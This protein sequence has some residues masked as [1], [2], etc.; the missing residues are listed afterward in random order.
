MQTNNI[1]NWP[2]DAKF[3]TTRADLSTLQTE[4][5]SRAKKNKH[6]AYQHYKNKK[7]K[8]ARAD[9]NQSRQYRSTPPK[10]TSKKERKKEMT[11]GKQYCAAYSRNTKTKH[12]A[13]SAALQNYTHSRTWQPAL[14][15]IYIYIL[16]AAQ[17]KIPNNARRPQHIINR[18]RKPIQKKQTSCLPT[19][20]KKNEHGPISTNPGNKEARH[21][22]ARQ[23]KKEKKRWHAEI[24]T[25]Q[26]A[27]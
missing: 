15:K 20:Q 3:Q 22:K 14:P 19:L 6:R 9:I 7:K 21:Q 18:A 27:A 11:C 8:R 17:C 4:Y 2:R 1:Y 23:K 25:A 10:S 26:R 13:G 24:N 5:A 12:K 16:S